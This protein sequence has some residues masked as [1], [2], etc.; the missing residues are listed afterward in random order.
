M[1]QLL[2]DSSLNPNAREV[3]RESPAIF[4]QSVLHEINRLIISL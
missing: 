2:V 4:C 3:A 1:V